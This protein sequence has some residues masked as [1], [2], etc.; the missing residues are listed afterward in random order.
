MKDE[1]N[2]KIGAVVEPT[3]RGLHV[4]QF[5]SVSQM[6]MPVGETHVHRVNFITTTEHGHYHTFSGLTT[7]AI[8]VGSYHI[9]FLQS[10]TD[11]EQGHRHFFKC[12]TDLV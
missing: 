12:V 10:A 11:D 5:A 8:V 9:H 3:D 6:C 7:G 2:H 4:H 1:H